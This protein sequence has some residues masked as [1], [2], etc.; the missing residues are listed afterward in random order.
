MIV[1]ENVDLLTK[2]R[3]YLMGKGNIDRHFFN[4]I[5]V[6]NRINLLDELI[7]KKKVHYDSIFD[8]AVNWFITTIHDES[9][10]KGRNQ[11]LISTRLISLCSQT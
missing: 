8:V 10:L 1:G 3:H 5:V 6:S 4:I 9:T 7:G 11:N 2:R